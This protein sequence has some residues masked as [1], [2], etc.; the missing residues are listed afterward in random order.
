MELKIT[1]LHV[2][3]LGA[4]PTILDHHHTFTFLCPHFDAFVQDLRRRTM[5][6]RWR[7][8]KKPL[9]VH[10]SLAAKLDAH[11]FVSMSG[12]RCVRLWGILVPGGTLRRSHSG[13]TLLTHR[14]NGSEGEADDGD[15]DVD[16]LDVTACK[17]RP[18]GNH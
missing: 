1:G 4:E 12:A 6:H 9:Y 15:V 17:P 14:P 18:V 5:I 3:N 8:R 7:G 11:S 13:A 2:V 10:H 16:E